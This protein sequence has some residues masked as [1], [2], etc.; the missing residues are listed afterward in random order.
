MWSYR[1]YKGRYYEVIVLKNCAFQMTSSIN[2]YSVQ[3][4]Q[5]ENDLLDDDDIEVS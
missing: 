5:E 4:N 1:V 2:D 3:V